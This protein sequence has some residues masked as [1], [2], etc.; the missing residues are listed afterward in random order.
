MLV[1]TS[2]VIWFLRDRVLAGCLSFSIVRRLAVSAWSLMYRSVCFQI[3]SGSNLRLWEGDGVVQIPC[4]LLDNDFHIC[5]EVRNGK[6][7]STSLFL[8]FRPCALQFCVYVRCVHLNAHSVFFRSVGVQSI[9][10]SKAFSRSHQLSYVWISFYREIRVR[11]SSCWGLRVFSCLVRNT[12]CFGEIQ[13][14]R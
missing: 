12:L 6:T 11:R 4:R 1:D 13:R 2:A 8:D 3:E 14:Q 5:D 9:D 10:R 7:S